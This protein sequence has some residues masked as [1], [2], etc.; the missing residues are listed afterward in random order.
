MKSFVLLSRSILDNFLSTNRS[1]GAPEV[2]ISLPEFSG[3]IH[4]FPVQFVSHP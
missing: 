2:W 1:A 4:D 3:N